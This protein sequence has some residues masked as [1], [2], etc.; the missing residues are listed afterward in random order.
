MT[1]A[2]RQDSILAQRDVSLL[3]LI[4]A[5]ACTCGAW[6]GEL[7]GLAKIQAAQFI[8]HMKGISDINAEHYLMHLS[9]I[10]SIYPTF[11]L[12][13]KHSQ[14]NEKEKLHLVLMLNSNF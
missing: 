3:S 5:K 7:F 2:D 13:Q 10:P 1:S 9:I 12:L 4:Q 11:H 6:Q 8:S 14:S